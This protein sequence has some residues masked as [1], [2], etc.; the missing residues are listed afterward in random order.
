MREPS[1]WDGQTC[2]R[3]REGQQRTSG[4]PSPQVLMVHIQE[5][6]DIRTVSIMFAVAPGYRPPYGPV[7]H[8][9]TGG[10]LSKM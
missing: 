10:P 1:P 3:H 9:D 4:P 8:M 2:S 5:Q 7:L 6:Q